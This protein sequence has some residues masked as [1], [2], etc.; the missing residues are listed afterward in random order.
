MPISEPVL[1]AL[2][3]LAVVALSRLVWRMRIDGCDRVWLP[4]ELKNAELVYIERL[5]KARSPIGLTARVDRGYRQPSGAITLVE[6][7][8]RKVARPY[9]SDV[10]ELSAQRVAVEAQT[11]ERVE[12]CGYVLIQLSGRRGKTAHRVKLLSSADVI[13]LAKRREAILAG[14]AMP[15]RTRFE[16]LC[17]RCA[18]K[19]VCRQD[20]RPAR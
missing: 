6:L 7:K 2:G 12:D 8:T 15:Q 16:R 9:L 13:A 5:F 11:G 4:R 10:I 3:V 17:E 1:V 20:S 14:K 18:F 19:Q